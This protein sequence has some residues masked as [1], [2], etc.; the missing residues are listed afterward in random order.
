MLPGALRGEAKV[1]PLE[2]IKESC[3]I[4][5][6]VFLIHAVIWELFLFYSLFAE[7]EKKR[8]RFGRCWQT[9][10]YKEVLFLIK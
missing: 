4:R 9:I 3:I 1:N 5:F 8:K 2:T 10:K 6:F 7:Q